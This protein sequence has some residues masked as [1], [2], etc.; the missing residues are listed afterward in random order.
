MMRK[1]L[2]YTIVALLIYSCNSKDN[3]IFQTSP[4]QKLKVEFLIVTGNSP[5]YRVIFNQK[6]VLDTS[7]LGFEFQGGIKFQNNIEIVGTEKS[8]FSE[9]WE[10]PWGEQRVVENNYNQLIIKLKQ[11]SSGLLCNL[12]FK[13]YNDG[14]GFRYEFPQQNGTSELIITDE[15]TQFKLTGNH[16]CWWIPGDWDIYEHLYNTTKF[17]EIDATSKRNH[18]ALAQTYIPENAVNTPFTMKTGDGLYLSFHEADLTDYAGMTLKIDAE[19][20]MMTSALVGSDITGYKVKRSLPFETPWRTIQVSKTAGGLIESNLILNLNDPNVLG[21]VS[22]W[23]KP[24]KYVGIWWDMHL[25]RK[26]WDMASGKHGATTAYAKEL[27]DFA[28]E[29][30]IGGLLVEG[31]NTGWEHWIGFPDREGV[32]DFVTCYPDYDLKEVVRYG[33]EK[34]VEL[35]MHHETSAAPRTYEQQLDTAYSLMQSLGI[36]SVKTGYVGTIIPKGEY[37]EGQW[38]INHFQKV[39]ETA[40]KYHIAVDAHE[41]IKDTGL[42]RTYP[43]SLSR[44]TFRGQEF[45]AWSPDGGNP[46]EHLPI[47]AFTTMLAGPMDYTPGIFNIKLKPYKEH[48]QVNTT[49]AQQLALYVVILSPVQMAADLIENYKGHP[50]FQFI[51]DVPVTWEQTKVLNGE[52]GDYVTIAREERKTGNWFVGSLTDE[53]GR[54]VEIKLDFLKPGQKYLATIYADGD[55]ADWD[56]NPTSYKIEKMEVGNT[57]SLKLKLAPGGGAAISIMRK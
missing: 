8:S 22:A 3:K 24:T 23:V 37:H 11:K 39:I 7:L 28:S 33:K 50:A 40:A 36:H 35:I 56:K 1:I 6:T 19:K 52:I 25:G 42:R 49:L 13:V 2:L 57:T 10:L 30:K 4:D 15:L 45:N 51:R 48:N 21:D 5:V 12:V 43:N 26:S 16:A 47:L 38:M 18:P 34:G 32:F 31:W 44:E 53:N 9:K 14:L 54:E 55:D 41:T 46:P 20:L 27:I 29:N 17:T